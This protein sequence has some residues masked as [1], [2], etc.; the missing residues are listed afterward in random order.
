MGNRHHDWKSILSTA[1]CALAAILPAGGRAQTEASSDSPNIILIMTD[2]MGFSDLG[3]YGSEISTPNLNSLAMHGL[4]FTEF[5]NSS[6]CCSTRASLMTGLYPHQAGMGQMTRD[7][8]PGKPGYRGRLTSSCV[9]IGE[10]L[11]SARY[12]TFQTGKWHLGAEKKE[13]W[14]GGRGFDRYYGCPEGGGFYFCPSAFYR[15][16]ASNIRSIRL[17]D[18]VIYNHQIDPPSDWYSTD[19]WT[20]EGLKFVRAAVEAKRPFFWYLAYNAPHWPLKAKPQD[21]AKYRGTYQAGWDKLREQRYRKLIELGMLDKNWKITDRGRGIP[22]WNSLSE[23]EKD[24]QDLRMATY[25]AAID[26]VDQNVGKIIATL[27]KLGMYENTLILFLHDNGG[28]SE[29]GRLGSNAGKGECGTVDSF[30]KYGACWAN[31]SNTPFRKYKQMSHEGGISTPLIAHW[32]QGISSE[33]EG[34]LV[35]SP[36]NVID[37]MATCVEIAKAK[38]PKSYRGNEILPME[39]ESL[40]RLFAGKPWLRKN[41]IYF[42]FKNDQAM[43]HGKWKLVRGDT[44]GK[45]ELYDMEKDRTETLDLAERRPEKVRGMSTRFDQWAKRC[46]VY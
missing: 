7:L 24:V 3:C 19:A 36:T 46:F 35:K 39:G 21:I 20:D 5:Y 44:G 42:A 14:P 9:T 6:V 18:K 37:V 13:Q 2:D 16:Q 43:R 8:G 38:Y 34:T 29:G 33:L 25:A 22:A 30:V 41:P 11:G 27:K 26:C 40:C 23:E 17:D 31:V 12:Q 4:R 32:P 1:T 15:G 10:V 45:W 28:A